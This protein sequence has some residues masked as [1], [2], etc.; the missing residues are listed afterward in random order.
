[1]LASRYVDCS[2]LVNIIR[3]SSAFVQQSVRPALFRCVLHAGNRVERARV[4][5][6]GD[7]QVERLQEEFLGVPAGDVRRRVCRELRFYAAER[8]KVAECHQF[9]L[10]IR[11][12]HARV[13][14]AEAVVR[15]HLAH[16][17]VVRDGAHLRAEQFRLLF[18]A[19]FKPCLRRCC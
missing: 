12:T 16:R 15:E 4:A 8:R 1:M 5:V 18:H 10:G 3:N 14:V 19:R 6:V 11:E 13:V 7:A 9:A 2:I 17:A